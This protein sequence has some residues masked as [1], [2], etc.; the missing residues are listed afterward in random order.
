MFALLPAYGESRR[1]HILL[2]AVG[3][4]GAHPNNPG[5]ST[6]SR[7][8]RTARA[9][10]WSGTLLDKMSGPLE[11]EDVKVAIA[12]LRRNSLVGLNGGH[13]GFFDAVSP[14]TSASAPP[15][16]TRWDALG[17]TSRRRGGITG[18]TATSTR[19]WT[20][21]A[22]RTKYWST[23]ISWTCDCTIMRRNCTRSRASGCRG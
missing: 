4:V 14:I 19:V 3:D 10:G 23:R 16:M 13:G 2:P 12:T 5:R 9:I 22:R 8:V 17:G 6:I 20:Q 21:R 7:A 18:R 1:R 15:T 11:P